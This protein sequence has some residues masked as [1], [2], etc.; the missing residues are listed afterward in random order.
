MMPLEAG[1]FSP[2]PFG[3][4]GRDALGDRPTSDDLAGSAQDIL[5]AAD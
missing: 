5:T 4:G 1:P 2:S 3:R